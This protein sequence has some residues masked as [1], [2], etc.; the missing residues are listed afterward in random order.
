MNGGCCGGGPRSRRGLARQFPGAAASVLPGALLVLLPKCPL[1]LAV[2]LTAVTGVGFSAAGASWARWILVLFWIAA[3]A[4][5]AAPKV[6]RR[7][8]A[9]LT[10]ETRG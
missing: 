9:E 4:L 3:L 6:R 10:R 1:C 8:S 5:V 7:A 2:W